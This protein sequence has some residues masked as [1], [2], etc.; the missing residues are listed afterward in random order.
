MYVLRC[1]LLIH[2]TLFLYMTQQCFA[3]VDIIDTVL[4]HN[5][6]HT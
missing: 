4:V 6:N 2:F 5:N 3:G 1:L